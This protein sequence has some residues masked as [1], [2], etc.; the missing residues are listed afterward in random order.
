M[1]EEVLNK[2]KVEECNR[3]AFKGGSARLECK[4]VR[5]NKKYSISKVVRRLPG[6]IFS[7]CLD[8]TTCSVCKA[9]RK[10]STEEEEMRQQQ[11]MA[12]MK[13]LMRKIRS[14]GKVDAKNRL[15][16]ADILATECEKAWARAGWENVLQKWYE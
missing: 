3:E 14:K 5:K 6:K 4:R 7:P 12:I 15:W 8:N 13:D 16:V 1:E 11:R 9:S 2:Y 10:E